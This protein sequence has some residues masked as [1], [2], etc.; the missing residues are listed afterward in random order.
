MSWIVFPRPS[1]HRS[2]SCAAALGGKIYVFGG[3]DGTDGVTA[4]EVF[5]PAAGT[6]RPIAPMRIGRAAACAA[7][8]GGVIYVIGGLDGTSYH[9]SC[10]VYDPV[11]NAWTVAAPMST[12]RAQACV[13]VV[14]G[15]IFVMGGTDASCRLKSCEVYD[16][17]TNSWSSFTKMISRRNG[18][19]GAAAG[20]LIYVMG[21]YDGNTYQS[22]CDMYDPATNTWQRMANMNAKRNFVC[23]ASV[24]GKVYV[25]GG[26][27][28][29]GRLV[30]CEMYDPAKNVWTLT[31]NMNSKR[32]Y[33]SAVAVGRWLYA[34]GGTDMLS[35]LDGSEALEVTSAAQLEAY[36]EACPADAAIFNPLAKRPSSFSPHRP[37]QQ[38][39]LVRRSSSFSGNSSD[40]SKSMTAFSGVVENLRQLAATIMQ[41]ATRSGA[42]LRSMALAGGAHE[43]QSEEMCQ[44]IVALAAARD[45]AAN[46]LLEGLDKLK[47]IEATIR[48]GLTALYQ[49]TSVEEARQLL[50]Q[51]AAFAALEKDVKEGNQRVDEL[52]D[53]LRA[54]KIELLQGPAPGVKKGQQKEASVAQKAHEDRLHR[55]GDR[56]QAEIDAAQLVAAGSVREMREQLRLLGPHLP[57]MSLL[58][59]QYLQPLDESDIPLRFDQ[60]AIYSMN[61]TTIH[62]MMAPMLGM[63]VCVKKQQNSTA[64]QREAVV[65]SSLS[66]PCLVPTLLHFQRDDHFIIVTPYYPKGD[67]VRNI[68]NVSLVS[69]RLHARETLEALAELHL[70]GIVHGDIKPAN[71]FV[72]DDGRWMIGDFGSSK[73]IEANTVTTS[74]TLRFAA[75]ETLGG[76]GCHKTTATDIYSLGLLLLEAYFLS[77]G[78]TRKASPTGINW[79][80]HDARGTAPFSSFQPD[81]Q[82]DLT[83]LAKVFSTPGFGAAARFSIEDFANFIGLM[84]R[85]D[86]LER[87]SAFALLEHPFVADS[88]T[89]AQRRTLFGCSLE[90]HLKSVLRDEICDIV[91]DRKELLLPQFDAYELS[92]QKSAAARLDVRFLDEQ[93][94][95]DSGLTKELCTE[96]LE[97]ARR[98]KFFVAANSNPCGAALHVADDKA[99]IDGD[100]EAQMELIGWLLMRSVVSTAGVAAGSSVRVPSFRCPFTI[101]RFALRMLLADTLDGQAPDVAEHAEVDPEGARRV[102]DGVRDPAGSVRAFEMVFSDGRLVTAGNVQAWA[103]EYRTKAMLTR[104]RRNLEALRRGFRHD[105]VLANIVRDLVGNSSSVLQQTL[106]QSFLS[107]SQ[108]T[109]STVF[110]N[111]P[112]ESLVPQ[113]LRSVLLSLDQSGLRKWLRWCTG[114]YSLVPITIYFRSAPFSSC[115]GSLPLPTAH[116]CFNYVDMYAYPTEEVL[117]EKLLMAIEETEIGIS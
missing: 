98:S 112:A 25:V 53:A 22:S 36:P 18:G 102:A 94:L 114:A 47:T 83:P 57:E 65:T 54:V 95:D 49:I 104:R 14:G 34:I 3:V 51:Q 40:V 73:I 43:P 55:D 16:P 8:V 28:E 38:Q 30:T 81:G 89:E 72:N 71:I 64:V 90:A 37:A 11:R 109:G 45:T 26:L 91:V 56:L 116:T 66:S 27:G 31:P 6:W 69:L 82:A 33:A 88:R 61:G 46:L 68:D 85:R 100:R 117:R 59:S 12:A 101:S 62:T 7:V 60:P 75:P 84:L 39:E 23:A 67:L 2:A 41:E 87:P 32:S 13:A 105:P 52:E 115:E 44:S 58:H 76:G 19:C 10:D 9:Y 93:G 77:D 63:T 20:G 111:F 4:C 108:V 86:P 21:G 29:T 78:G 74:T 103:S 80:D 35:S 79:I 17:C 107:P 15:K 99:A 113:W 42:E 48:K 96:L 70:S 24:C 110:R 97:E 5:D 106:C 50:A 92:T 1:T